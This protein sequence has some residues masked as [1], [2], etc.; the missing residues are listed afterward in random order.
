[1]ATQNINGLA[2]WVAF[3]TSADIPVLK[4]TAR[5]LDVL[6]QDANMLS[7]RNVADAIAADPMLT[8]KLLRYLQQHKRRSQTREVVQVEQALLMLGVEAFYTKVPASPH[9]QEAMQGQTGA[10]VELLHVVHRSHRASEFAR[11]WAIRLNDMH[12]EEV[13]IAA[14][15]H[16]L[17][18]ML[19][20]CYVPQ[21]M[22]KIRALQQQDKTL[23]SR[24]VQEQVLGFNLSELQKMLVKEWD[25][26]QLL[27]DLMDDTNAAKPRVR[28]VTLAVNLARH[29]ANGWSDAALPD[30]Y[31]DLGALLRIP[32]AEAMGLVAPEEGN[33]CELGTPH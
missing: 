17:S 26:P 9:V 25:L 10:L 3:L 31:R 24:A 23:R 22:L 28:N 21:D 12:Y 4:Q 27:L 7:A 20:W 6:R 29:S 5:E 18:E 19:L 33:A 16:D 8:A 30:D 2:G 13:R 1:M 15:L 14:L 11:D 32:P